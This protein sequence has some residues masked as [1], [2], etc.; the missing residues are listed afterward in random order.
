MGNNK[1]DMVGYE[2][3]EVVKVPPSAVQG[4]AGGTGLLNYI[5]KKPDIGVNSTQ[6]KYAISFDEY[7]AM[8]NSVE[9]DT[10]YSPAW[11]DAVAFRLAGS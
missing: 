1:R 2:R 8:M 5:L 3:L 6:L 11:N 9:I 4:R 10:N 7:D